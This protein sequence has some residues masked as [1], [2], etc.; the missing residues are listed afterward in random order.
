MLRVLLFLL[1]VFVVGFGFAWFADRPGDVMLQWQG[2]SYQTSLMVV[3]VGVVALV[4]LVMI[5]WWLLRSVLDSPRLVSRFF[6]RRRRDQ[7][8]QALTRGLIAANSGDA[9]AARR[10][11]K[12][13]TRLL[14]AGRCHPCSM[15]SPLRASEDARACFEA[16]LED[17]QTAFGR[18][19]ACISKP[20]ARAPARRQGT[21]L[22]RRTRQHRRLPGRAMPNC[23]IQV[24]MATGKRLRRWKPTAWQVSSARKRPGASA[25][26]C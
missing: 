17:D 13:S 1:L 10:Y 21:M 7:G 25:P 9:G 14:A 24:S 5:T 19:A 2:N 6:H 4:A 16:M 22:P 12:E 26:C 11:T 3:L 8:Y 18:C 23:A 20:S 15:R